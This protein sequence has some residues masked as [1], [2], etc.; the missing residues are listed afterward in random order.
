MCHP[1][2]NTNKHEGFSTEQSFDRCLCVCWGLSSRKKAFAGAERE[3][4]QHYWK[5]FKGNRKWE[6][7][8]WKVWKKRRGGQQNGDEDH[9]KVTEVIDFS[10]V[11]AVAAQIAVQVTVVKTKVVFFPSFT[12]HI[13]NSNSHHWNSCGGTTWSLHH[14]S[15]SHLR[16][17]TAGPRGWLPATNRHQPSPV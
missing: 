3:N 7:E 14:Q 8:R 17:F 10:R 1:A 16:L 15:N 12:S 9:C 6:T 11:D 4:G 2:K 5:R 13:S